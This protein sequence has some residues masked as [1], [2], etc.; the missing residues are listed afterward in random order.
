MKKLTQEKIKNYLIEPNNC[1]YCNSTNLIA[2][3]FE[4]ETS[5]MKIECIKCN[6]KWNEIFELKTI[7]EIK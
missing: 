7:E 3:Y 1:P 2:D 6:K 5:S 4:T